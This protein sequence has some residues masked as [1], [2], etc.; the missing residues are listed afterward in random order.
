VRIAASYFR[1][2]AVLSGGP[3]EITLESTS[4]CNLSCPMC[5]RH[6]YEFDNENMD[7]DL[8]RK[9]IE[10]CKDHVEFV[11]PYG[12]GEPLIH[13]RIFEMIRI[14]RK[15]GIRAGLS[16]N[17]TLLD[18]RRAER[19]L[20]SGLDYLILA[21]DGATRRTYE[22]Y[23][24][25]ASFEQ[26][27]QNIVAFLRKKQARNSPMHVVVQMVVLKENRGEIESFRKLWTMSGV[28]EVR[29]KRDELQFEGSRIPGDAFSG[30]RRNPCYLLWRGPM[31]VSYDGRVHPCCQMYDQAPVGDLKTQSVREV[32]NSPGMVRLRK[33]HLAGDLEDYPRC[34]MCQAARPS[35][36]VFYG[37]L[38]FSSFTVRKAVPALEKLARFYNLGV[39]ET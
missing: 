39:F 23:R 31:Y 8:Y 33:A 13:P 34:T 37:S 10:D 25:G 19:L 36:P 2:K 20:D 18:E 6:V 38:A 30:R 15:A 7:L 32:W 4:K 12:I 27:R 5:P 35:L 1:H 21:F 24:V 3:I 22:T 16:T 9:I 17:A 26:S 14:T 29:F 28:D 11:W